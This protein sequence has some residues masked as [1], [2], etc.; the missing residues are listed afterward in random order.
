MSDVYQHIIWNLS[1][2]EFEHPSDIAKRCGYRTATI[3]KACNELHYGSVLEV[4]T[5]EGDRR[6]KLYRNRQQELDFNLEG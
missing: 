3:R 1:K 4:K 5:D 2:N 6:R